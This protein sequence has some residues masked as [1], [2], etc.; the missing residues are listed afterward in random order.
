MREGTQENDGR[1]AAGKQPA[2]AGWTDVAAAIRQ[3]LAARG[4]NP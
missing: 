4:T 1:G 2:D 3:A